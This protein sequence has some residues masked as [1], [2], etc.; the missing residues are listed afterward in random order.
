M[1]G[2]MP[3]HKKRKGLFLTGGG[4]RGAY[5][6]GVLKAISEISLSEKLP[7]DVV[8]AMSAG[9]INA[10]FLVARAEHFRQGTQA[11]VEIWNNLTS[12]QVFKTS[13]LALIK[14]GLKTL[15]EI[16]THITPKNG[17]FLLDS[18][19]LLDLINNNIDFDKL[20]SHLQAGVI[21]SFDVAS[22]CYN[23]GEIVS[24]YNSKNIKNNRSKFRYRPTLTRIEGHHI[25][26]SSA[27]PLF[28]RP[29][30]INEQYFGDGSLRNFHPF[31]SA[32]AH[33][34]SS[35]LVIDVKKESSSASVHLPIQAEGV[36]FGRI[37]DLFFNSAFLD[38]VDRDLELLNTIN[39][40]IQ[41]LPE[42]D[43]L[44]MQFRE[45]DILCIR[46]SQDLGA[47]AAEH[48]K[49][50]PLFLRYMLSAFGSK[51]QSSDIISYLL[52]E[53]A[54]CSELV[55]MGYQDAMVQQS[56]IYKFLKQD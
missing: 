43:R 34:S 46:P 2:R 6:A 29:V 36:S 16:V 31:R 42:K 5:Q 44:K 1:F 47:L 13:T 4:A 33:E 17:Q 52:F 54:F 35:L 22:I 49:T 25:Y 56:Q 45:I 23:S 53:G 7:F 21:H 40:N 20:N 15:F 48:V 55:K 11:L 24:F 14:S 37:I 39:G 41:S 10:A 28:F 9:S 30:A 27:I 26:A 3:K 12:D 19:P 8:S 32:I 18:S 38:N 50:L 51:E